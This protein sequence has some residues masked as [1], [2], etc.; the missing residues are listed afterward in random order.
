MIP[1]P[2]YWIGS[3]LL[4][5]AALLLFMFQKST[6]IRKLNTVVLEAE[7]YTIEVDT[8]VKAVPLFTPRLFEEIKVLDDE[9][10]YV[11]RERHNLVE[12]KDEL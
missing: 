8:R 1:L 3:S 10:Y 5:G 7:G 12:S 9:N 6:N 2:F 11:L 4:I